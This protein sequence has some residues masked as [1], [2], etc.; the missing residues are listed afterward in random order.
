ME[1]YRYSFGIV[2]RRGYI[3]RKKT[4][5]Y[6]GDYEKNISEWF[7]RRLKQTVSWRGN[8]RRLLFEAN[9]MFAAMAVKCHFYTA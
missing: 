6:R 9:V 2:P 4:A 7:E 5:M 1:T 3:M 8:I